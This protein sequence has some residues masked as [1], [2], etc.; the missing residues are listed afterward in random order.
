MAAGDGKTVGSVCRLD[1]GSTVGACDAG[2]FCDTTGRCAAKPNY[3]DDSKPCNP[4]YP[5][6]GCEANVCVCVNAGKMCGEKSICVDGGSGGGGSSGDASGG[7]TCAGWP[8]EY[9]PPPVDC[10]SKFVPECKNAEWY[11][12]PKAG[13]CQANTLAAL[14]NGVVQCPTAQEW[15]KINKAGYSKF[16][17][18]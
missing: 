18:A 11:T 4:A 9:Q 5:G 17:V 10:I 12:D 13:K 1:T 7:T 2:M 15:T 3:C 14:L 8:S 6:L 16:C